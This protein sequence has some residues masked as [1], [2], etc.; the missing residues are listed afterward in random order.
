MPRMNLTAILSIAALV[1]VIAWLWGR[2]YWRAYKIRAFVRTA[3]K[4]DGDGGRV[5]Y[6]K[7]ADELPGMQLGCSDC[8]AIT[9]VPSGPGAVVATEGLEGARRSRIGSY[10]PVC[11]RVFCSLHAGWRER[12]APELDR[13]TARFYIP[14]CPHCG[15]ETSGLPTGN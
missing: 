11:K 1:I 7:G 14:Y 6:K 9:M 4:L 12:R 5:S 8:G 13:L 3:N 2:E 10:C 15:M